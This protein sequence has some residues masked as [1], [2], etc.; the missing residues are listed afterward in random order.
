[1]NFSKA[2]GL[3]EL[4]GC[5]TEDSLQLTISVS[6]LYNQFGYGTISAVIV[7]YTAFP[8]SFNNNI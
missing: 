4:I 1:M 6:K 3:S 7:L 2:E 5:V 8:R